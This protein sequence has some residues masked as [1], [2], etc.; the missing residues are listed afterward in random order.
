MIIVTGAAGF[1]GMHVAMRLLLRGERVLGVDNLDPYYSVQLKRA[2]L[3]LLEANPDFRFALADVADHEAMADLVLQTQPRAIVHMAAQAG[4]RYSLIKPMAYEHANCGG[5]LSM[6]Q[7]SLQA[8]AL[9]HF[10][11]ASSSS[12]Y[13]D[14]P[15]AGDGFRESE[16]VDQP[17]SIYAATKRACE[18]MSTAFASLHGAAQSG[19]RFFTAYGPWG[20]PDMAYFIFTQRILRGEPIDVFGNGQLA[21]DFTYIDDIVDGVIG[22]LDRPPSAGT[23]RILNIGDNQ[24]VTVSDMIAIL[25]RKLGREAKKILLPK[26]PGDVEATFAAIDAIADLTGYRPKAPLEEGLE[27]FVAWYRAHAPALGL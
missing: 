23:N 16:P 5:H 4:V 24:P 18:L 25:E 2:R 19:L 17:A 12:V 13:G 8:N 7:A 11:Y 22:V 3:A 26:Q 15:L 6:L 20:R 9:E 21:R 14:R 27:R 10:V 1:I